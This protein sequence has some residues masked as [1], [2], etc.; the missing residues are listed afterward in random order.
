MDMP[1]GADGADQG[2]GNPLPERFYRLA[3]SYIPMGA[4]I[5]NLGSGSHFRF[6]QTVSSRRPSR[7]VSID[8]VRPP[9]IP[10]G[11]DFLI[12]DATRPLPIADQ[13]DVVT[14]F[15]VIEHVDAGDELLQNCSRM[16]RPGGRLIF[17]FPNL[18]SLYGRLELLF[19]FQPHVLEASDMHA[20]AGTGP[21]GRANNPTGQSLHHI[22]GFTQ[23][24]MR[25][26]IA[27]HGFHVQA[28][29]GFA[30]SGPSSIGRVSSLAPQNL[31]VCQL[32]PTQDRG[33]WGAQGSR[34]NN[35]F[36]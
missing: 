1:S 31:F 12:A 18:A 24:A 26:L 22:R 11:V 7:V 3:A 2:G 25:E 34:D 17:S 10:P 16:L 20:N 30:F 33:D 28:I 19:G 35:D 9:R 15:E 32:R 14:F 29:K 27:Y 6:E 5:L 13:F 8:L 23:R 36:D 21:M 4:S